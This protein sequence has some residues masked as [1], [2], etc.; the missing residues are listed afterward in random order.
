MGLIDRVQVTTQVGQIVQD[1]LLALAEAHGVDAGE[2]RRLLLIRAVDQALAEFRSAHGVS[3]AEY[4]GK[5]E[6][7]SLWAEALGDAD[8]EAIGDVL[9]M[10]ARGGQATDGDLLVLS[11]ACGVSLAS[12]KGLKGRND[13]HHT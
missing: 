9:Q 3:P 1:E 12:I 10:I 11:H 5:T 13:V 2:Y 8:R 6:A 4:L 7:P